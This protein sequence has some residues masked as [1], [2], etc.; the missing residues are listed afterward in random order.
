LIG[1][2]M[3]GSLVTSLSDVEELC[4]TF[5]QMGFDC[6]ELSMEE[7]GAIVN[8][9]VNEHVII[10]LRQM[11]SSFDLDRTL[12]CMLN[13]LDKHRNPTR[14]LR[15][16]IDLARS[17]E[18][19]ILV[20]HAG[21]TPISNEGGSCLEACK[22]DLASILRELGAHSADSGIMLSIENA[23]P[24]ANVVRFGERLADLVDLIETFKLENVGITLDT[25]HLYLSAK[26]RNFDFL[27]AAS[28]AEHL[29]NHLHLN[30]NFGN[31]DGS[32]SADL[33][34]GQGD[35]HLPLEW[36]SAPVRDLLK[37]FKEKYSGIYLLD[38]HPRF[39]SFFPDALKVVQEMLS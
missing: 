35:L 13:P 31:T 39:I 36:G 28:D 18:A 20:M 15:S 33:R 4:S 29:V 9:A 23:D 38:L 8:Y 25:G 26:F 24:R 3:H 5:S 19:K 37:T 12:H 27:S 32:G 7:L 22:N 2:N 30:D 6:V 16:V 1:I 34:L 11:L 14:L 10:R 17:I 21:E